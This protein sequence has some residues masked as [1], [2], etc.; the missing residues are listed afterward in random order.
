MYMQVTLTKGRRRTANSRPGCENHLSGALAV[1]RGV[2]A[3]LMVAMRGDGVKAARRTYTEREC[4]HSPTRVYVTHHVRFTVKE[5]L[6]G[7]GWRRTHRSHQ[8]NSGRHT[9]VAR[10]QP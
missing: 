2:A 8:G 6:W 10:Q 4:R 1:V 9:S 7:E 3:G 5:D